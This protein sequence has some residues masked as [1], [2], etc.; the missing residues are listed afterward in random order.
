MLNSKTALLPKEGHVGNV[1]RSR[2]RI[3]VPNRP[4]LDNERFRLGIGGGESQGEMGLPVARRPG[5]IPAP[6]TT[7]YSGKF[8]RST[9]TR[10]STRLRG[11]FCSSWSGLF[12]EHQVVF[13]VVSNSLTRDKAAQR[14]GGRRA[15]R[16]L[17]R[18]GRQVRR[19][20]KSFSSQLEVARQ[21]GRASPKGLIHPAVR[22]G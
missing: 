2:P 6:G 3:G 14:C 17:R 22:A 11:F 8:Q 13:L 12:R 7:K 4:C 18:T 20:P 9:D 16:R 19:R 1:R 15:R 10:A 21:D 5:S